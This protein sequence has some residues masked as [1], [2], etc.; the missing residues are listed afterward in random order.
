M[1]LCPSPLRW[2][3][4]IFVEF[5]AMYSGSESYAR[6]D[7]MQVANRPGFLFQRPADLEAA[8]TEE[9][10]LC[11]VALGGRHRHL[12]LNI[13]DNFRPYAFQRP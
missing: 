7:G 10:R 11:L 3:R 6:E 1:T 2:E 12:L 13:T 5:N 4:D 8:Q 9:V